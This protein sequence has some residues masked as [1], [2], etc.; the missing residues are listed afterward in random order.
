MWMERSVAFWAG[1]KAS[2]PVSLRARPSRPE[3]VSSIHIPA[4]L[5]P[6][7]DVIVPVA[8]RLSCLQTSPLSRRVGRVATTHPSVGPRV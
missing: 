2:Q 6:R 5:S 8:S 4:R 3:V 1:E 7:A